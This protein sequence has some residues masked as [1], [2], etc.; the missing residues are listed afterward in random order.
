[1]PYVDLNTIHNPATGTV[2][3]ATWGD[4]TR[5][6][7]EFLIDPPACSVFHSGTQSLVSGAAT[8][9][10][11]DSENFDNDAMHSNVT[12]NSRIT[13]QTAG[14]YLLYARSNFAS[15][16]TGVRETRFQKN[17]A[18]LVTAFTGPPANGANTRYVATISVVAAV[19][20]YF[21]VAFN[22]T[23]GGNLTTSLDEFTALYLTR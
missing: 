18:L 16:A 1:V 2:A 19:A 13:I 3:P 21:E 5:D 11:A 12:N 6:N 15:N 7:L 20:D 22:Q 8:I 4:Q 9:M 23:S 17:G 10:E 14:R